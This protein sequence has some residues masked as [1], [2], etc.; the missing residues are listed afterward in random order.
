MNYKHDSNEAYRPADVCRALLAA[1]DAADGRRRKRKRDQTPDAMGLAVKRD[2]LE[3]AVEEDPS[4]EGFEEWLLNY[5]FTCKAP[6]L[7]GPSQAMARAVFDEW[8]LAH[9]SAEFRRWLQDGA[10]SDDSSHESRSRP[11]APRSDAAAIV[12]AGGRSSRM[13]RPKALLPFDD[14]P[15]ITHVVATLGRLVAEVVV[16]AAPGQ[17]LPAMPVTLV[18]DDVAYQGPVGGLCYGLSATTRDVCFVTS[19]DS[20]FL[21]TALIA[22]LVS[23]MPGHDVVVPTWEGRLQP[24]HAVYRRSVL[25]LLASQLARGELR[26]VSLF[27]K[28]RTRRI[29]E[30]EIRHFDPDGW[31]FFNMNTPEDYAQALAQWKVMAGHGTPADDRGVHC[32]VELFGV[33]RMIAHTRVVSLALPSN[34]TVTHV[35][36]ALGEKLPG[37]VGRV[38]SPDCTRLVDGYACNINGLSFVRTPTAPVHPGDNIVVLSADAGG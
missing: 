17:D 33:A 26:P 30:G 6:E 36:G 25:P 14:Q 31:S 34:A 16:V 27:D 1:L 11:P 32:T 23:E 10:P 29:E 4:A 5:P 19:C 20:A 35:F 9:S 2:L 7:A 15:L 18:C 3:R 12:L 22:H 28:V 37:L 38:I 8:R 24:L 13:G 21:N